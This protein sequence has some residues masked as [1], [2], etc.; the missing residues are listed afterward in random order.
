[1]LPDIRK[2]TVVSQS[3]EKL[4]S[5]VES[6]SEITDKNNYIIDND[7]LHAKGKV[8][9]LSRDQQKFLLKIKETSKRLGVED[10]VSLTPLNITERAC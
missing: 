4:L 6:T 9:I 3:Q 7:P 5:D 1:M 2:S 10:S 8:G